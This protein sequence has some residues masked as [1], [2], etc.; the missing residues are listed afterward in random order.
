MMDKFDIAV[1]PLGTEDHSFLRFS[2]QYRPRDLERL[3]ELR[4]TLKIR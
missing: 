1:V 2:A 3:S 4:S